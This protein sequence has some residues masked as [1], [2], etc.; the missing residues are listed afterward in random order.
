MMKYTSGVLTIRSL[1]R[2]R[3][4]LRERP[5][6]LRRK[7]PELVRQEFY[8]F[9]LA[10]FTVCQLMHEAALSVAEDPDRL[11]LLPAVRVLRR[12]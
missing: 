10:H 6:V 5:I 1:P 7:T 2:L 3:T 12:K 4:H 9:L 8:G 11:C